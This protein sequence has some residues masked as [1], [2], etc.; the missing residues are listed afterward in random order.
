MACTLLHAWH[1]CIHGD[2]LP[3]QAGICYQSHA[4]PPKAHF[5]VNRDARHFYDCW[6]MMTLAVINGLLCLFDE[7][8]TEQ[9]L[10]APTIDENTFLH[11]IEEIF[12]R[13]NLFGRWTEQPSWGSK[14]YSSDKFLMFS[15]G[16]SLFCAWFCCI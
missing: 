3:L 16:Q 15:L 1:T 4:T 7:I 13:I 5:K 9:N 10:D 12:E 2:M 6:D 11:L 8:M 14:D